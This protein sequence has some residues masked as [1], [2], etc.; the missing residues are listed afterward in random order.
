[1]NWL[2]FQSCKAIRHVIFKTEREHVLNCLMSTSQ[3]TEQL[4]T[5]TSF[6]SQINSQSCNTLRHNK[7]CLRR[8]HVFKLPYV[9]CTAQFRYHR[10]AMRQIC[11]AVMM[12]ITR[13]GAGR[14]KRYSSEMTITL[15]RLRRV[16]AT[17]APNKMCLPRQSCSQLSTVTSCEMRH[18]TTKWGSEHESSI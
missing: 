11:Y 12:S 14:I 9:G 5:L 13:G 16:F 4:V 18:L 1:M 17:V 10:K 3:I 8:K 2:A 6:T 7:L 15:H